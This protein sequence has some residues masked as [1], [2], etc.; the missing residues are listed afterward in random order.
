[1]VAIKARFDGTKVILPKGFKSIPPGDVLVV[2]EDSADA[3]ENQ[4]W[5]RGQ[6]P[7]FEKVWNNDEDA[8]Y[9]SL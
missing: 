1:M 5:S 7:A 8:V 6:E 9:D 2:F 3:L 4:L